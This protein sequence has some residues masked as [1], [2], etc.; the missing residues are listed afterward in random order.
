MEKWNTTHLYPL[1]KGSNAFL[2][3]RE[4]KL[5]SEKLYKALYKALQVDK[6]N[7]AEMC[8]KTDPS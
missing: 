7:I 1:N 2:K 5:D 8:S 6:Q 3:V 4:G